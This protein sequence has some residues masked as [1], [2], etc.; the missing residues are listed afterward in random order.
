MI[1]LNGVRT[2]GVYLFRGVPCV[3]DTVNEYLRT[4]VLPD[5]DL[6]CAAG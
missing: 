6:A 5:T 4:G 1:T 2:H 3:D